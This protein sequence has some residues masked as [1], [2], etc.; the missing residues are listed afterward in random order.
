MN[1]KFLDLS[2]VDGFAIDYIASEFLSNTHTEFCNCS[3]KIS[4]FYTNHTIDSRKYV[5]IILYFVCFVDSPHAK[6]HS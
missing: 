2:N 4:C 3:A 5:S 1:Y 6:T